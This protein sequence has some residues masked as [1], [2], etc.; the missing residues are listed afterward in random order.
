MIIT[1]ES[2]SG[3]TLAYLLP[4]INDL[5]NFKDEEEWELGINHN[6]DN[7]REE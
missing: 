5:N 7:Y 3:K 2:G 1:G 4:I 6:S